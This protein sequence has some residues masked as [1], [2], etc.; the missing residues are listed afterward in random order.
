MSIRVRPFWPGNLLQ[1]LMNSLRA[2]EAI[3]ACGHAVNRITFAPCPLRCAPKPRPA[4]HRRAE[5][6][7]RGLERR[8][9]F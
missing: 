9:V 7:G 5:D 6:F 8:P 1:D 2:G 3:S 4:E